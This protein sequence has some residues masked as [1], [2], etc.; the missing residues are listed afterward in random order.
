MRGHRKA[1]TKPE[2]RVRSELHRHGLRFRNQYLIVAGTIRIHADV[3]FP[4]Q[5][6]A[7]FLDGCFWHCCPE[8]ENASSVNATYWFSKLS[9]NGERDH[10][11]VAAL[12][13]AGW[14]VL[15]IWENVAAEEAADRVEVALE[16]LGSSNGR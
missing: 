16:P 10:E 4:P 11:V 2:V 15:R 5:R 9:R 1:D 8:H 12:V 7:V 13:H 6:L 3:R 14:Q